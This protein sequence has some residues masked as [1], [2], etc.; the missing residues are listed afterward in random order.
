MQKFLSKYAVAAH[1]A[2]LA[3]APLFLFPFFGIEQ[4][5]SVLLW[6]SLFL[7]LWIFLEPS[8][9]ADEYLYQARKRICRSV[10]SD[11]LFWAFC[12]LLSVAFVRWMNDGVALEWGV[13]NKEWR[14]VVCSPGLSWL[15]GSDSLHG[16]VSFSVLAA[17]AVAVIAC[18]HALGKSAR[19]MFIFL[20]S[21]FA[22]IAAVVAIS[23][24]FS[25]VG[26]VNGTVSSGCSAHSFAGSGFGLFFLAAVTAFSGMYERG[27]NSAMIL[28]SFAAG[29]TF[30]GLWYF[31]PPY[32]ILFYAVSGAILLLVSIVYVA[33][34]HGSQAFF[35]LLVA[36][37]I[38]AAIPAVII[39]FF[40]PVELIEAKSC[41]FSMEFFESG[42]EESR[43]IYSAIASE[44][45]Q[46]GNVW[47]G[48]GLGSMPLFIKLE[49]PENAWVDWIP[50]GWRQL[51]VERGIVGTV[52]VI[53]PFCFMIFTLIVRFF[54]SSL[55]RAFWPLAVLGVLTFL[56]AVAEGF[57]NASF[58]RP[59]MFVS[60]G[61]FFA[62][63]VSSF[64]LR[65]NEADVKKR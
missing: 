61:A 58:F 30:S 5:S 41:M 4:T 7:L 63:G 9:R 45:W 3:V 60:V 10:V 22:G 39:R 17:A 35:K 33:V 26:F 38:A 56:V 54:K 34:N 19:T 18:R 31:A 59:E 49:L 12:L 8:R 28:F 43:K 55:K 29:A 24:S 42:Y 52:M 65:R 20:S 50:N 51:L 64:P 48:G 46:H 47:L 15:P 37:I 16:F 57:F 27:W 13:V 21:L 6:I 36:V 1:L 44:V 2:I 62:I 40:A 32:V 14:W 11:P 23:V 25:E 53:I